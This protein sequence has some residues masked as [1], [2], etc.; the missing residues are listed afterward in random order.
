[1]FRRGSKGPRRSELTAYI[2]E[3]SEMEGRYTF[4]GTVM[5][6]GRFKGEISSEDTLII[7]E[8]GVIA[9][10]IRAGRVLVSGEV[11]GNLRAMERIELKRT[12]R[13][14]G[15]VEAPVVVLEEGVLFEGH[16]RMAKPSPVVEVPPARDLAVVPLKR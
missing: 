6:N 13:V 2:D 7:G 3:G 15:D 5:L 8:R 1:M 11:T 4:R 12:A 10:D 16:C 9:A 14:Y